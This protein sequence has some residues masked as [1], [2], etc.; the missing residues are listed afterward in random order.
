MADG[1]GTNGA[2]AATIEGPIEKAFS[3][4]MASINLST[5]EITVE[6]FDDDFYRQHLGGYGVGAR[7]A[8]DRIP[9]GADPLGPDNMLGLFPGQTYKNE[10][11]DLGVGETLVLY[12]DGVSEANDPDKTLFGQER[13]QECFAKGAGGTAAETV[14]RLLAAVRAFANGAPQSDDIT[15]LALRRS[16]VA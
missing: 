9:Q 1:N 2:Q 11:L 16:G 4:K 7:L 10:T 14:D 5:G 15:I 13:L 8:L 3:G 6:H 12:T